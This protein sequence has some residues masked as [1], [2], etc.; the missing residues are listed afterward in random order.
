[1]AA[2]GIAEKLINAIFVR[3]LIRGKMRALRRA[4][5]YFVLSDQEELPEVGCPAIHV[6]NTVLHEPDAT[7]LEKPSSRND[8]LFVGGYSHFQNPPAVA[9]LLRNCWPKLRG[10]HPD[11]RFRIVGYGGWEAEASSLGELEGGEV[12]G[13]VEEVEPE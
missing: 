1:M 13:L 9:W 7:R 12:R 2:L 4:H 10:L 11:C 5:A 8:I 6:P 3:P